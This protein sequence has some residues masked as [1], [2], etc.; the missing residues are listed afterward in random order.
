[1]FL[2]FLTRGGLFSLLCCW[3]KKIDPRKRPKIT[4]TRTFRPIQYQIRIIMASSSSKPICIKSAAVNP[5]K[6]LRPPASLDSLLSSTS[7]VPPQMMMD[8]VASVEPSRL[9]IPH[10]VSSR[11]AFKSF[12]NSSSSSKPRFTNG[13]GRQ[14]MNCLNELDRPTPQS[15][16]LNAKDF[17]LPDGIVL[18]LH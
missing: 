8:P 5:R 10:N 18:S 16:E 12:T 13:R 1:M 3:A 4:Q 7:L 17:T 2:V 14:R 9:H 15:L 6:S 11:A